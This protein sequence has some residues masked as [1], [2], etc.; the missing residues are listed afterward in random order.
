M[1]IKRLRSLGKTHTE[2]VAFAGSKT[3]EKHVA[4]FQGEGA[5]SRSHRDSTFCQTAYLH[6]TSGICQSFPPGQGGVHLDGAMV[7]SVDDAELA[8][9]MDV[10]PPRPP[11]WYA[12]AS[13]KGFGL[14]ISGMAF[15]ALFLTTG[16]SVISVRSLREHTLDEFS[17]NVDGD[18]REHTLDAFKANVNGDQR[19]HTLDEFNANVNGDQRD[20]MDAFSAD[21]NVDENSLSCDA[22]EDVLA[23]V[24]KDMAPLR[25][26]WNGTIPRTRMDGW[27][28]KLR[29]RESPFH[30]VMFTHHVLIHA[31]DVYI[32]RADDYYPPFMAHVLVDILDA[33]PFLT[34]DVEFFLN[35]GDKPGSLESG[36]S[37]E[38]FPDYGVPFLSTMKYE[39]FV[40]GSAT[41][42]VVTPCYYDALV[43]Q[44]CERRLGFPEF[45]ERKNK[46]LGAFGMHC[47]FTPSQLTDTHGLPLDDCPRGYFKRLANEHPEVLEVNVTRVESDPGLAEKLG[48]TK[49]DAAVPLAEHV[50]YKYLLDTD[51]LGRSCKF[52]AMLGMGSVVLRPTTAHASHF[53]DALVPFRHYVPIQRESAD[54]A[55]D[56]VR[57]LDANPLVAENIAKAGQDFAC[58]QLVKPARRC[59]WVKAI[60]ELGKLAEPASVPTPGERHWLVKMTKDD[61]QCDE[62]F[63]AIDGEN[64]FRCTV[65]KN[66][67]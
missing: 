20:T 5:F 2:E 54:D 35:L 31:R 44:V 48:L 43:D 50:W 30:D 6:R 49:S 38:T 19:E 3:V 59:F 57:W 9:V 45:G 28:Q 52:E 34:R 1:T 11:P 51:G 42:D 40:R 36:V 16:A 23:R 32:S 39:D 41:L 61:L 67:A 62:N 53:S 12:G 18:Q 66:P 33:A 10:P 21:V 7:S 55:L 37:K 46:L 13:S 65:K 58:S 47:P 24:D 17:A 26:N 22:F 56:A 8:G 25:S 15:S 63:D 60:S 64:S 4:N 14:F 27:A 29:N